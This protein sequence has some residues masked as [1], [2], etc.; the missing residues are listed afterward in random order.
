MCH[1]AVND[2]TI[3]SLIASEIH[4]VCQLPLLV[5]VYRSWLFTNHCNAITAQTSRRSLSARQIQRISVR[6]YTHWQP[7][8]GGRLSSMS[9]TRLLLGLRRDRAGHFE[10]TTNESPLDDRSTRG[11]LLQPSFFFP[12]PPRLSR[13][14]RNE[15]YSPTLSRSTGGKLL[16]LST[17]RSRV[18]LTC[19]AACNHG[20]RS[21]ANCESTLRTVVCRSA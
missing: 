11:Q 17:G 13:K 4:L 9:T 19:F 1:T 10:S 12:F 20:A 14:L 15:Y 18:F 5:A 16:D 3:I 2:D 7:L 21:A 8:T 6:F